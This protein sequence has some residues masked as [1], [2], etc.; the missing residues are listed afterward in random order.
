MPQEQQKTHRRLTGVV[1]KDKMD[2]TVV[3]R[4]DNAKTHPKYLKRLGSKSS[5]HAHDE[6]NE[7]H[8]GDKVVIEE[9]RPISKTKTWRVVKI[10]TK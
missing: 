2:K 6:N 3:V 7:T 8:V 10:A 4:V 9:T 5:Y 1:V